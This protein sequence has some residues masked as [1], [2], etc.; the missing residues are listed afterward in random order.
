MSGISSGIGL[1]SGI[2]T[3][4]LIDQ[5]I[6]LEARPVRN[7]Q[8]RVQEIDARRAA[9]LELSAKLLAVRNAVSNFNK[10]TFFR[11]FAATSTNEGVVTA[12][13]G[14]KALPGVTTMRVH[15]LVSNHSLVSR[16]FA[17]ADRTTIGSGTI[18]IEVGH[19]RVDRA[20][21]L[22]VLNGGNGIRRGVFTITDGTGAQAEIDL[23]TAVTVDDLLSAINSSPDIAV[24]A[25][26]TG[27]PATLPDGTSAAGDR[28]VIEDISGGAGE[29]IIADRAGSFA[30]ADLGIAGRSAGGRIDSHD[31]IRLTMTTP[32]SLLNDRNG[33]DRFRQGP[34]LTFTTSFGS[35][36]VSLTDILLPNTDVRVL[37]S[38]RGIDL[39]VFRITDRAGN[40]VDVDLTDL[41]PAAGVTAQTI[42]ERIAQRAQDAGLNISV[43]M[44][45]SG[46]L[47]TDTSAVAEGETPSLTVEDVQGSSAADLGIAGSVEK[48]AIVGRAVYRIATLGDVVR[49]I[50]FAPGNGSQV[51]AAVSEDGNGLVLTALGFDNQVTV[52]AGVLSTGEVSS[53]A[54]D[55]GLLDAAFS[56]S[57][58]LTTRPL[59][60][61][62]NTVLL[63]SLRG[64]SGIG[65]GS[66][67]FTDSAGQTA[68]IDL[69]SARTLQDVVDLINEDG[70][71]G[72]AASVNAAGNGIAISDESGGTGTVEIADLSGTT[73]ADLGLAGSHVLA[74]TRTVNGGNAQVQYVS[75]RTLLAELNGGRGVS[76]GRFQITDGNGLVHTIDLAPNLARTGEVID[77][78][79]R[80]G[81]DNIVARI[82]DT[83]DG[84]VITDLS[85]GP[86]RLTV[87]DLEGGST[88]AGL[89]LAG[90]AAADENFIDG[91]YELK[92]AVSAG[93]TLQTIAAKLREADPSLS[94]SV[95]NDGSAISPFSLTLTSTVSGRRGALTIDTGVLD[96]GL[97]TLSE[98]RDAVV[99]VGAGAGKLVTSTSNQLDG[100]VE[101]VSFN[102]LSASDEAVT[103][104]V[105]Q[106][107]DA[108]VEAVRSFVDG[109]NEVQEAISDAT[110][111]DQETFQKGPLFGDPT[112]DVVRNRLTRTIMRQ[113]SGVDQNVSHLFSIGLRIGGGNQL[114]FDEDEFRE[115]YERAPEK[116]ERLFTAAGTGFGTVVQD[117]LD[118]LTRDF[119]G[120]IARKNELLGERQELLNQ[121]IGALNVLL[122][123]KRARL[124]AQFLGLESALAGLQAQQN[125]LAS[126]GQLAT[127]A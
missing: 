19:G 35:F 68:T 105:S 53:A 52:S 81:G 113:F 86:Q 29:L 3:A 116:V 125:A 95:I 101:G 64:G 10:V 98:A 103:V 20:T 12:T 33:M 62:L 74:E 63:Q 13:A 60:A 48:E 55:L 2:N 87:T 27:I 6:E 54:R 11:R 45:N 9:F 115:A 78:I 99:T 82:N 83:G 70:A 71:T 110:R 23:R 1:I 80:A 25:R 76:L 28:I 127:G 4:E 122:D 17:D 40:S 57:E 88:A 111:F 106:D 58:P 72:L 31:L 21:E 121:R 90:E 85:G 38:G 56:S 61:G 126:L 89:R 91:S 124:E 94:A 67:S 39:G 26:V 119:D 79:N 7:L 51:E 97:A 96:L 93:D 117:T 112:V 14:E 59:L 50:N 46:F 8:A 24:R 47:I 65:T 114:E 75:R 16:G 30:A 109:Y 36:D 123:A 44:L 49:A 102:L 73:A 107:V 118:E 66:V 84:I 42:R 100:I 15:S 108:I 43:T 5:L 41:D 34:D 104:S 32:L 18:S 69:S 77:A 120:L 37:N 92:I 22:S